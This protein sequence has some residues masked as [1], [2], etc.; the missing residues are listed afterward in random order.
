M[1]ERL[2][3]HVYGTAGGT[4]HRLLRPQSNT[5]LRIRPLKHRIKDGSRISHRSLHQRLEAPSRE[6][7]QDEALLLNKRPPPPFSLRGNIFGRVG[8]E[9]L[10][11]P[12]PAFARIG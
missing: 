8:V 12:A 1:L 3:A 5:G 7:A 10:I 2:R 6:T 4:C 9:R 11:K